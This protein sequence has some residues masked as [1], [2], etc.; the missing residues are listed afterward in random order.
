M[1]SRRVA[2]F[3]AAVGLLGAIPASQA[4]AEKS[5]G[6]PIATAAHSCSSSYTHAVINGAHKCLRRGQYCAARYKSQYRRYGFTCAR[7][8]AGVYR[9]R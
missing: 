6:V 1:R 4:L 2:A 8:S 9:L 3:V 5:P 7:D